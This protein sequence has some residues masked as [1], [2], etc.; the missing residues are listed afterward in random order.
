[1]SLLKR[2]KNYKANLNEKDLNDKKQF[3]WTRKNALAE[4]RETVN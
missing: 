4:Q 3:C 1:M 2:N